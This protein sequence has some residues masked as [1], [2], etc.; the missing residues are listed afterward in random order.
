LKKNLPYLL[1][2]ISIALFVI[3][4][5]IFNLYDTIEHKLLDMRFTSR[6][7]IETRDD[8]ATLDIDVRALQKEGKWDPWSR[9]KHIPMVEAAGQ[10]GMDILAFDIYFIEHSE[11]EL[12]FKV[13]SDLT[14]S[15]VTMDVVKNLFPDPDNDLAIAAKEAKNIYFAQSF[16]PQPKKREKIKKRTK[17]QDK[18]LDAMVRKGLFREVNPADFP[19]LFNFYDGEFPLASFIDS[20][21]GV[22]F[23]QAKSD[24][25]GVMRKY[26]LVGLYENRLFPSISLSIALDHYKTSFNDVEIIPGKYLRFKPAVPDEFGRDMITIPINKEGL[27]QVNWAGNWEDADGNFDLMHYPYSVLKDFQKNEYKNYVLSEF[28]RI[29]NLSYD[30]NV[31]AAY[32]PS[33]GLIN[34]EKKDIFDAVKKSMMMGAVE[35]WILKNPDGVSKDF[36]KVPSFVFNEI[37][38]NNVIASSLLEDPKTTLNS[39]IQ[40]NKVILSYTL[41]NYTFSTYKQLRTDLN[42]AVEESLNA[43]QSK[44]FKKSLADL[45]LIERN[46]QIIYNLYKNKLIDEQ[47]PLFFYPNAERLIAGNEE[48]GNARLIVPFEFY[49]KKL[50]YGLTA[51][52]THDL[53]PMPFNPRYPMVGLHANALNTILNNDLIHEVDLLII[54]GII[55]FIGVLL[56]FGVPALTP[57]QGGI[58]TGT[59]LVAYSYLSFWLFSNQNI[60]LDLFGPMFTLALGYLGIT[61]YNYIQEEKNKQFLKES[62][63]TYVSPELID[64]M[65]ESGEEPSLGGSE[66]YH[67]AFFTDIQS[68]SAFSEKLSATDL[69]GL[70]NEYLTDMTDVLLE[71]KGTLDKYIGDAIVAFY[72]APIPIDQHELWAC[73]TAIK[74]QDNLAV[75]REKWQE[76]GDRWPEIV[77]HMQNRIGIN[78]GQMVTGN[79]GS[80]SRMNYTMMGDTVNLAARLEASAKQYGVYIQ[81]ADT[82]YQPNKE[83]LVVRD[84]DFV[85]VMGK[86]EPVQVWELIAEKGKESEIYNKILPAYHEALKLYKNQ[87]FKQAIDAFKESDTLEDMFPGRKTNPSRVYIPRCEHFLQNPPGDDWDGVWTLTSK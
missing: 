20:S 76:E 4:L 47:R 35:N 54:I 58:A 48:K 60:W 16:K 44:V 83:I 31:K 65:Y 56:A 18:R 55:L 46:H 73:K 57:S 3:F 8:I 69:V 24:K 29:T 50:Y 1:I 19:T 70:L 51:T 7:L 9:E 10:H 6:G 81:I 43:D 74:M 80:A 84:L 38:N 14:D 32:K 39:L 21:A 77:H 26:P 67:T 30:K 22:Y 85:R 28:K 36:K 63:G 37:K 45:A 5:A 62:F 12:N 23:F 52:G 42:K 82:T 13:L 11:R 79:M 86:E 75:L 17:E 34:A 27:M 2:S 49:G 61:V 25:D 68:F 64:Q 72:G 40:T 53:N 59:I 71:N 41:E 66:G 87:D 33:L 78:T 15:L